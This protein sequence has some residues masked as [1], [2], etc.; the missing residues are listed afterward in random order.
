MA[1]VKVTGYFDTD[2]I[3]STLVDEDHPMGITN[4]AYMAYVT[5]TEALPAL[6]DLEFEL[7]EDEPVY[8]YMEKAKKAKD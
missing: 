5:G 3:N 1:R 4:E 6:D 8:G 7:E 2:D